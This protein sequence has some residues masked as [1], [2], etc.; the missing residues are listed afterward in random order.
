MVWTIQLFSAIF[1]YQ[2]RFLASFL[3]MFSKS[4]SIQKLEQAAVIKTRPADQQ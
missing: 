2:V 1:V 4:F 3:K